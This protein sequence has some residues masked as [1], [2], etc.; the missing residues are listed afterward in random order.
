MVG[1]GRIARRRADAVVPFQDQIFGRKRLIR[2]VTPE[3]LAHALVHALGKGFGEAIGQRL[4]QDRGIVVIG[5]L[6]AVGDRILADPGGDHEG[7]DII[8]HAARRQ[9]R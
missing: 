7:A 9:A 4:A 8:R 3:F 5:V 2:R 6:E 1:L